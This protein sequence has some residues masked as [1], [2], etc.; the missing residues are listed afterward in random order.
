MKKI[1][2]LTLFAF[3]LFFAKAQN[4]NLIENAKNGY[5]KENL[6]DSVNSSAGELLPVI[7]ADGK[8]LIFCRNGHAENTTGFDED[9]WISNW[10]EKGYWEK[11]INFGKPVN[12]DSNNSVFGFSPD[13]NSI[14]VMG[15]YNDDGSHKTGGIST[16]SATSQG[17]SVPQALKVDE[18]YNDSHFANYCLSPSQNV[19]IMA[20][21][22]S[23]SVGL[24]D[25]WVSFR[26]E[27]FKWTKPLNMGNI[28]NSTLH[29]ASPFLAADNKTLYF[30]SNGHAGYG[31]FDLFVTK[32]LDDTWTNWSTPQN[33]GPEINTAKLE[34]F[35][36]IPAAGDYAYLVSEDNAVGGTDIFK[37]KLPQ[38]AKPDPVILVF[39]KVSYR[40]GTPINANILYQEEGSTEKGIATSN[41]TTGDYKIVL[42]SGKKYQI[43]FTGETIVDKTEK[44]DATKYTEYTEIEK[45]YIVDR[46]TSS[47]TANY[48]PTNTTNSTGTN[49]DGNDKTS[50]KYSP[51]SVY[52][53]YNVYEL[54]A[55]A[56]AELEKL[57]AAMLKDKTLKIRIQGHTD[58]KGD[59][60]PN[61]MLSQ[62][63]CNSVQ[64]FLIEKGI[65]AS[66]ISVLTFGEDKPVQSNDSE[67][68]RALNRRVEIS[69]E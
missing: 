16:S 37:I 41:P 1:F 61:N 49:D 21:Q 43:T 31:S 47:T 48:T 11:A 17:W 32:R 52:F 30:A 45:N 13:G 22:R 46:K 64:K 50:E 9:I 40:D 36:T 14:F 54:S 34:A 39:G 60:E 59:N 57:S 56:K 35:Y 51:K 44:I 65:E 42:L 3:T 15:E 55:K 2:F 4:I 24:S 29:E 18:Y 33:L 12:N 66:R 23:E 27:D 20:L 68:G 58:S 53:D 8:K 10:N 6:G 38:S 28:I 63:R 19:I 5:V 26:E 25:L 69:F 7:S 67:K 62:N